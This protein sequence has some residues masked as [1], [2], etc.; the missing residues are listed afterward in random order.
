MNRVLGLRRG[1]RLLAVRVAPGA[2]IIG[3]GSALI[4]NH[5]AQR[6]RFDAMPPVS[7]SQEPQHRSLSNKISPK[8]VQQISSGSVTGL[9]ST[10]HRPGRCTHLY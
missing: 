2:C 10:A 1:G 3:G 9:I 4:L 8:M 7:A 6:V 5:S